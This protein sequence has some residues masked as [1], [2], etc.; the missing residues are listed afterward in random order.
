MGGEFT[1][2]PVIFSSDGKYLASIL[3]A[4]IRVLWEIATGAVHS[5]LDSD[6]FLNSKIIAIRFLQDRTLASMY[7]DG[8]VR[9]FDQ[10]T[11]VLRRTLEAPV[12]DCQEAPN[13]HWSLQPIPSMT[14]L[15][16][17]DLLLLF[18]NGQVWIWNWE[19]NAWSERAVTGTLVRRVHGCLSSGLLVAE[20]SKKETAL[21]DLCLLD[22]H[23]RQIQTI[24]AD[25]PIWVCI[26]ISSLDIIAWQAGNGTMEL[27]DTNDMS[28]TKL[29]G[30]PRRSASVLTF[31]PD[32]SMLISS[33]DNGTLLLRC[34]STQ[35]EC[36]VDPIAF[37]VHSI[38]FSPDS[39][40]MA[41][42]T[43]ELVKLYRFP[44]RDMS[45]LR[46]NQSGRSLYI[47]MSPNGQQIAV[48]IGDRK[49]MTQIYDTQTGE[50]KHTLSLPSSEGIVIA[51]SPK[52]EQ[53]ASILHSHTLHVWDLRTGAL[54]WTISG[55]KEQEYLGLLTFSPDGRYL[56]LGNSKGEVLVLEAKSGNVIHVFEITAS[57]V[58][59]VQF[60]SDGGRIACMTDSAE[61]R[62]DKSARL[63]G[64][65]DTITG[66]MLHEVITGER[67]H[68]MGN[69]ATNGDSDKV[70]VRA[71]MSPNGR[72][73]VY[74]LDPG[75]VVVYDFEFKQ[76][77]NFSVHPNYHLDSLV[78]LRDSKSFATRAFRRGIMQWDVETSRLIGVCPPGAL[79]FQLS[80][81]ET[82]NFLQSEFGHIPI[83]PV[84]GELSNKPSRHLTH[85]WY[86]EHGCWFMEGTRKML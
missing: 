5:T 66:E 17:G 49:D 37:G 28:R 34:L 63:I 80:L 85:W 6:I 29:E 3:G 24:V 22:T 65:W 62:D 31:S 10:V 1:C 38:A 2:G 82:G 44:V 59:D 58:V 20:I 26:A 60:S 84:G 76:Q 55:A 73:L 13:V 70:K 45:S 51:F 11:G 72:Y 8:T 54:D 57:E 46:D 9:L 42:E 78:F 67:L 79:A 86:D 18:E 69:P 40:Q 81:S 16:G 83:H 56:V 53:L 68:K 4:G 32:G 15:P 25:K 74:S 75:T 27:I 43:G 30:Y 41:T 23:T 14:I 21:L 47:C 12:E 7:A 36:L 50:L 33:H 19:T 39:K 35:S 77:R 64:V 61:V 71:T 52:N 48:P